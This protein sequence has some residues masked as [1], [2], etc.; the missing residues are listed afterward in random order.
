VKWANPLVATTSALVLVIEIVAARMVAPYVGVTL[1]TFSAVIGCVLGAIA[2]GNWVGGRLADSIDPFRAIALMCTVGGIGAGLA[3]GIVHR[4]GPLLAGDEPIRALI[5][6]IVAFAFPCA[7]LSAVSPVVVRQLGERTS[8]LGRVA[9]NVSAFGT[10]G[11]L[12][13]N[14][15]AGFWLVGRF[16][17]TAILLGVGAVGVSLGV[18]VGTTQYTRHKMA[19]V[20]TGAVSATMLVG[21]G[22]IA[23][24]RTPC[25]V[26]TR[27]V[28]LT[29][30]EQ[31]PGEF[32]VRSNVY[33][34]SYTNVDDP[35]DLRLLYAR[36]VI[37]AMDVAASSADHVV[38]IGGGGETL[39]RYLA[40]TRPRTTQTV[41]EIDAMLARTVRERLG[42]FAND[43]LVTTL[44]A[45]ARLVIDEGT[46]SRADVVIGDAFSGLSVPWHLTTR[47]FVG[48]IERLLTT[49]GIY[50]M[51]IVDAGS[52][53][54]ARAELATLQ[55][56]FSDVVVLA[57]PAVFEGAGP[58]TNLVVIAGAELPAASDFEVAAR[59]RGSSSVAL[60]GADLD[61]FVDGAEI[62][63][64]DHAPTDQLVDA[65][66]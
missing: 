37:A 2:I 44:V 34:S 47:E 20:A 46:V 45:D 40:T 13:G 30:D 6:T 15:G 60:S 1:E 10:V 19:V 50:V 32:H 17:S 3:P 12:L 55:T 8:R 21:A 61:T 16:G 38:S 33:S 18:A 14:F 54:L 35:T 25:T 64:D 22:S 7:A 31:V 43:E 48:S 41:I 36:D 56:V 65:G 39:V 42:P 66:R 63:T 9:G 29:I 53:D 23:D 11:A 28:C 52:Y 59:N 49:D 57:R 51:N 24:A 62:L 4:M 27:Y 5:L 58:N 26:E